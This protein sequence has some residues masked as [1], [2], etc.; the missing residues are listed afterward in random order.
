MLSSIHHHLYLLGAK[1]PQPSW[2]PQFDLQLPFKQLIKPSLKKVLHFVPFSVIKIGLQRGLETLFNEAIEDGDFEFLREKWLQIDITDLE[3]S[4]LIS[5][6]G[7]QLIVCDGNKASLDQPL[8][9]V[10]FR[11]NSDDLLLIAARREDPDSLFFQRRLI[12][13]GDTELGLEVKNLIDSAEL[14]KLPK[15]LN[16]LLSFVA[17]QV[18]KNP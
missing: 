13:E 1:L 6:K 12:I 5:F 16:S 4:W 18:H 11:A 3:L 9:E 15:L 10:S 7:D 2:S 8:S 14:E 17:E